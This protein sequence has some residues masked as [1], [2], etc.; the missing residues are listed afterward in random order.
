MRF[1]CLAYGDEKDWNA[2][3]KR[4]QDELLAH[5]EVIRRRGNLV[6]AVGQAVTVRAWN[7]MTSTT[8]GPFAKA[9]VP[10]AGF[11]VIEARDLDEVIELVSGTPC[12]VARGAIEIWPIREDVGR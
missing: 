11:A 6:A 4:E 2:L 3:P 9:K 7:H 10:L 8:S 1:L 5:D 12:A